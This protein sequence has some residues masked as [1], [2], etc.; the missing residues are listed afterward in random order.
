MPPQ[1]CPITAKAAAWLIVSW[2]GEAA[3][4]VAPSAPQTSNRPAQASAVLGGPSGL[5]LGASRRAKESVSADCRGVDDEAVANVARDD[6]VIGAVHIIGADQLDGRPDV[7][8]GAEVE[9]LLGVAQ[10]A[11]G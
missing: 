11:D 4:A 6:P 9:H 3:S 10:A 1:E 2:I 8:L 7:V 5:C